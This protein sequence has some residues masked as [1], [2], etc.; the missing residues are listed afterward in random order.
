MMFPMPLTTE[1]LSDYRDRGFVRVEGLGSEDRGAA[2]CSRVDE[3][4]GARL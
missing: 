2:L 3:H 1:E 4:L